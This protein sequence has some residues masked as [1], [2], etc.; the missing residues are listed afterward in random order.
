M[1][2][3]RARSR[4]TTAT[5]SFWRSTCWAAISAK[6]WRIDP[7]LSAAGRAC[8]SYGRSDMARRR[9]RRTGHPGP[10]LPLLPG[11]RPRAG[12]SDDCRPRH[13]DRG[14]RLSPRQG[15]ADCRGRSRRIPRPERNSGDSHFCLLRRGEPRR[16]QRRARPRQLVEALVV[17]LAVGALALARR[18]FALFLGAARRGPVL[19]GALLGHGSLLCL[20]EAVEIDHRGH[21]VLPGFIFVEISGSAPASS[22]PRQ[23]ASTNRRI[24]LDKL[25]VRSASIC[26][27][28]A[29]SDKS[30]RAAI[31]DNA[32]QNAGSSEILVA[33][34]A[35]RT[36]R[37]TI[38]SLPLIAKR[39]RALIILQEFREKNSLW[40]LAA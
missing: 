38:S 34:P 33:C 9:C 36:D 20:P 39:C 35:I 31:S 6:K 40:R 15:G 10:L 7:R 19:R 8:H 30:R 2:T 11:N 16:L 12:V 4:S 27:N 21:C 37:L 22:P 17:E 13:R 25:P 1:P 26:D 32:C 28:S 5:E 23:L 29:L 3:S 24:A 14:L 18:G